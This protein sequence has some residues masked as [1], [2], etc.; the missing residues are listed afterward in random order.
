VDAIAVEREGLAG[1]VF[2]DARGH[3]GTTGYAAGDALLREGY[4]RLSG[5]GFPSFLDEREQSWVA[6]KESRSSIAEGAAYYAGWYN[7]RSF[8]DI[9]GEKGLARGAIAW[10]LASSEAVDIWS[11][12]ERGWCVNLLRR[13]AAV[14]WGPVFEPY[15]HAFPHSDT[16]LDAIL[17][18]ASIGEAYWLALPHVSWAMVLIGDPMYRPFAVARPSAVLETYRSGLADSLAVEPRKP[19]PL[20]V[21]IRAIGP[22]GS[23][24]PPLAGK[25]R[26]GSGVLRARGDIEVPALAAGEARTLLVEEVEVGGGAGDPFR[27]ILDLTDPAGARREAVLEGRSGLARLTAG[28]FHNQILAADSR[29]EWVLGALPTAPVAVRLADLESIPLALPP[30]EG[31]M[32]AVFSP[33]SRLIALELH[34]LG[35]TEGHLEIR[36]LSGV[37]SA[38]IP[39]GGALVR[40]LS[41]SE[42]LLG[43]RPSSG[44]RN[45]DIFR[46]DVETGR[47][48][49]VPAPDGWQ[50]VPLGDAGAVLLRGPRGEVAFRR[51]DSPPVEVLKGKG[52]FLIHS[53]ADDLSLFAGLDA[54]KSLWIQHGAG[55]EP[56]VVGEAPE[57]RVYF[58]P[59]G[60]RVAWSDA[61]RKGRIHDGTLRRTFEAGPLLRGWWSGDER[62][63][64]FISSEASRPKL[65]SWT[66][67]GLRDLFPVEGLGTI[68]LGAFTRGGR[69]LVLMAGA[70][71]E[72]DLW[73]IDL[74]PLK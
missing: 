5:A 6:G 57:G 59:A 66:E 74:E 47:S 15:V 37:K 25:V 39:A 73:A 68:T 34:A 13:G 56:E 30:G 26:A 24:L 48:V 12:K 70:D 44:P 4:E 60:R 58:G 35:A 16:F 11:E 40:W 31:V 72:L 3:K 67:D 61:G 49:P 7:L 41:P 65:R 28:G 43:P 53:A 42:A 55:E 33:D 1:R 21:R 54:R 38:P 50:G 51:G 69:S 19:G 14:T 18:G 29:G 22:P 45:R 52:P 17:E 64:V 63:F 2:V 46:F 36:A 8:Q 62:R 32:N 27:L 9:F 10:H 71:V 23:R 20:L